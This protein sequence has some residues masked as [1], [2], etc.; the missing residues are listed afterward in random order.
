MALAASS[1]V[2]AAPSV[3]GKASLPHSLWVRVGGATLSLVLQV[4][5]AVCG[6]VALGFAGGWRVVV[7]PG[8]PC[9]GSGGTSGGN[10][11]WGDARRQSGG[12][13]VLTAGS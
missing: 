5:G 9:R 12:G 7:A 6:A 11:G 10:E 8:R 1:L 4:T 13:A 2:P 3:A